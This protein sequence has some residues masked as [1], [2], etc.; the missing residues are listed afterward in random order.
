MDEPKL[1]EAVKAGDH[2]SAEAASES[3]GLLREEDEYG[4]TG[5]HWAA[6][7]GDARAARLLLARGTSA[8]KTG[9]DMRTP[10]QIALA[11]GHD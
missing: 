11:L 8:L 1:I 5:L 10:Y 3:A 4:W 7:K 6:A 9:R 2:A